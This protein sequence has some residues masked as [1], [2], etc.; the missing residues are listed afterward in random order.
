MTVRLLNEKDVATTKVHGVNIELDCM[1]LSSILKIPGNYG[2][3]D[4]V[5]EVWE[6]ARYYLTYMEYL[7]AKLPINLPRLMLRHMAYVISV[8][9]HELPYGE[10]L[11]RVFDTFEVPL[12][13]REGDEP[14]K[15]DFFKETFLNMS[16]LKRKN[17]VWWLGSGANRRRDDEVNEMKNE[18]SE[19]EAKDDDKVENKDEIDDCGSGEKFYDAMDEERLA[20][21][22]VPAPTVPDVAIDKQQ[23]KANSLRVDPSSSLTD[24][25]LLHLQVEFARALQRNTRF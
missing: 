15:T 19:E 17:G 4:Y 25:D 9:H 12:D 10:L 18:E 22:V 5:K 20:D 1:T 14:V 23:E 11:T 21:E 24:Y 2:F 7:T 6:E 13:D 8:P 16:Q 3:S